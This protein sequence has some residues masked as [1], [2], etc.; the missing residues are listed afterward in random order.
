MKYFCQECG[1]EVFIEDGQVQK[2]CPCDS[3]ITAEM[4]SNLKGAGGVK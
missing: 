2:T 3:A 4:E 1:K